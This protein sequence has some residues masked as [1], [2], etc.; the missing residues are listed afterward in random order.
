MDVFVY[1]A[2]SEET[3]NF[4]PLTNLLQINSVI[5]TH[6][7]T[8]QPASICWVI[9]GVFAHSTTLEEIARKVR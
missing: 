7:Q 9:T 6:V 5:A 4:L 8:E 2:I 3:Q 1:Y